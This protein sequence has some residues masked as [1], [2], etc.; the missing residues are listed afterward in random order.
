MVDIELSYIQDVPKE[1]SKRR[2]NMCWWWKKDN[3]GSNMKQTKREKQED[4]EEQEIEEL[5]A[6]DII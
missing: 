5:V 4:A 6:L 2:C 1:Q 3:T